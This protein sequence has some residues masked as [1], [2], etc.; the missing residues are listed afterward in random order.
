MTC[1]VTHQ[2]PSATSQDQTP[3]V[4]KRFER[5]GGSVF[6]RLFGIGLYDQT[7]LPPISAALEHTGRVRYEPWGRAIRTTASDQMVFHGEEADRL[8]ESERL[9][10]LHRDVKGIGPDGERYSALHPETWNWVLYSSFFVQRTAFLAVT[11]ERLSATDDQ[12]IWDHFRAKVSGLELPGR[13]RLLEDY[14]DVVAHY[15]RMVEE[16][17]TTTATLAAA[18]GAV[19]RAPRP[20]FLPPAAEPLWRLGAPAIRHVITILGC[21]GI[22]PGVRAR[23][24]ITWTRRHEREYQAMT[25]VLQ[26]AY[27]WLPATVTDTPLVRNRRRYEKLIAKYRGM[28]LESFVP[29][30]GRGDSFARTADSNNASAPDDSA[31]RIDPAR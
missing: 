29:A 15:D 28:G 12:A 13:S 16:K 27:R 6:L 2:Q 10:R 22:H 3:A 31:E 18:V 7:M 25:A 11:G 19:R 1:P 23:M 9:L 21:G 26:L 5:V 4:V 14:R 30:P 17:L 8:A 24:P 20:D